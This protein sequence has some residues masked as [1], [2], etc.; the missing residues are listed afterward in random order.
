MKRG[1]DY[2]G[3]GV[4]AVTPHLRPPRVGAG[5]VD[6]VGLLFLA[7]CGPLTRYRRGWWEFPG[8]AAGFDER[9]TAALRREIHEEYGI[10]IA[11][12]ELVDVA[13]HALVRQPRAKPDARL[14]ASSRSFSAR[15]NAAVLS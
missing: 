15:R 10:E 2:V 11:V 3:I 12:G 6:D 8:G 14:C 5:V 7:R 13:D 1:I 9:L 4:G